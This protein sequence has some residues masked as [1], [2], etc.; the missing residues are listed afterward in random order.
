MT[1]GKELCHA[2]VRMLSGSPDA[3]WH[4]LHP[5]KNVVEFVRFA[6]STWTVKDI[7]TY[8]NGITFMSV[9]EDQGATWQR[10]AIREFSGVYGMPAPGP[11]VDTIEQRLILE[12]MESKIP[13]DRRWWEFWR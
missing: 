9:S 12:G 8:S 10:V 4:P 11:V 2:L 5:H 1:D 3:Q 13:L 7:A 6:R